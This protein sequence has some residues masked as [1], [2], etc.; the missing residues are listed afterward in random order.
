MDLI[1]AN[2]LYFLHTEA[3]KE[4]ADGLLDVFLL[5]FHHRIV[6]KSIPFVVV[7]NDDGFKNA[8]TTVYNQGRQIIRIAVSGDPDGDAILREVK[9]YFR[10]VKKNGDKYGKHKAD[11]PADKTQSGEASEALVVVASGQE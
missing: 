6:D 9:T 2:Q 11:Y 8:M 10:L 1:F 3:G 7:S 4:R 5:D